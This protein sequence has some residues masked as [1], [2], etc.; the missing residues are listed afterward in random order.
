MGQNEIKNGEL[1]LKNYGTKMIERKRLLVTCSF[2]FLFTKQIICNIPKLLIKIPTRSRPEKLFKS[3]DMFYNKLSGSIPYHFLISC[4]IDDHLMNNE[5]VKKKLAA[6]PNLSFYFG[7]NN[8]KVQAYNADI[9]KHLDFSVLLIVSDDMEPAVQG[10][11]T[12]I[13]DTMISNFP[14]FDGV[15]HFHDGHVGAQ[16]NTYPIIGRTFYERFRYVYNPA[17]KSLYCDEELTMVSRILRKE[18]YSNQVLIFHNHPVYS[19]KGWDTLYA[20]NDSFHKIDQETF[21]Q[22]RNK[23]FDLS[24]TLFRQ[25][26]PKQLSIL[27]CTLEQRKE[28]FNHIYNK[29]KKQIQ[30]NNL[31]NKVEI[32][33][34]LDNGQHTIGFK[35]NSLLRQ[36]NGYYVCFVDDDDDVHENYVAMICQKLENSPDCVSLKGIITIDGREPRTF[37]H[38]IQY[39]EWFEQQ[40]VYYRPPNHLNPIRRNIAIQFLFPETNLYEDKEWSLQIAKSGLLKKEEVIDIPY[41]F[42]TYISNK[43]KPV[44]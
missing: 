26:F 42:Y 1:Y 25:L 35:R 15:L 34:F 30:D 11:D 21:N 40:K 17:Y 27:I 7:T 18:Y 12:I 39:K 28:A 13:M 37:L 10:Y 31:E 20:K 43:P 23:N 3:L 16:C 22:R 6:Y 33:Y 38:S 8:T 29:L 4:D 36:S 2:I 44:S 19:N 24:E 41:Y 32:L 14:D 9:D 5:G